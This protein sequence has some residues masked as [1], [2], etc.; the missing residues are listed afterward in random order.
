[1][2]RVRAVLATLAYWAVGLIVYPIKVGAAGED[3]GLFGLDGEI[4]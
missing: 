1:M 3:L 4:A 2:T